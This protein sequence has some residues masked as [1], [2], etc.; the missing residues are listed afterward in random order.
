MR[1]SSVENLLSTY[2]FGDSILTRMR[3]ISKVLAILFWDTLYLASLKVQNPAKL[4]SGN[5]NFIYVV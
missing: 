5:I 1:Y 4:W 3:I 2:R